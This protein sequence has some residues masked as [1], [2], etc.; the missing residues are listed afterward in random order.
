ML[1]FLRVL[2]AFISLIAVVGGIALG[3]L[4]ALVELI[5]EALR[6]RCSRGRWQSS[7]AETTTE[8]EG[9]VSIL[10]VLRREVKEA[11]V[12]L[13]TIKRIR[14]CADAIAGTPAVVP[15]APERLRLIALRETGAGVIADPVAQERWREIVIHPEDWQDVLMEA[16]S[17]E[18]SVD[19][20]TGVERVFG[21]EVE[22]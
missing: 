9:S 1:F 19:L 18:R 15:I 6:R 20:E 7:P 14:I 11:R 21:I 16:K 22:R 2:G 5:G 8:G 3:I 13:L 4:L 17:F 10:D 12:Q